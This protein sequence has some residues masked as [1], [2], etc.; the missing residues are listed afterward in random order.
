MLRWKKIID[1]IISMLKL[2]VV[3]DTYTLNLWSYL[4]ISNKFIFLTLF[5]VY[6]GNHYN[7]TKCYWGNENYYEDKSKCFHNFTIGISLKWHLYN[8]IKIHNTK[9]NIIINKRNIN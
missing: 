9:N 1:Q 8:E 2:Q 4:M 3:I 7:K 6:N 5:N